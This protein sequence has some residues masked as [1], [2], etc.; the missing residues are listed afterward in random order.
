MLTAD[1]NLTAYKCIY[2]LRQ[3]I[4]LD[5]LTASLSVTI[6]LDYLLF[7]PAR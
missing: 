6:K 2:R 5:G 7:N 1:K 3:P 4:D